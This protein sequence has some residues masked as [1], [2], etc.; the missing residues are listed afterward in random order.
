MEIKF[1]WIEEYKNI[2]NT[3]FNFNCSDKIE[4]QY[5]DEEIVIKQKK[6]QTPP[7]FYKKNIT[8]VTAIV[9]KNGSRKTNLIEFINFNLAHVTNGGLATYFKGYKGILIIDKFIF[10][11]ENLKIKNYYLWLELAGHV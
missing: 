2:K 3:G 7:H 6:E 8:G 4:F 11:Q 9:G 10:Y 5:I 1:I